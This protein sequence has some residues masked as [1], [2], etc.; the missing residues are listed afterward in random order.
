MW[1]GGR[2]TADPIRAALPS[3]NTPSDWIARGLWRDWEPP[4]NSV[5]GESDYSEAFL[6][7]PGVDPR[8]LDERY[9][10]VPVEFV[11][12][13]ENRHD[14]FACQAMISGQIIGYLSRECASQL[15]PIVDT[16]RT[17]RWTVAGVVVGGLKG[18]PNFGVHVWLGHRLTV[19]PEWIE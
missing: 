3:A 6:K 9:V 2:V 11:R 12:E 15:A 1:G 13:P 5:R 14:R 19:G 4:T 8:L 16:A 7:I 17:D 18:A 10:P